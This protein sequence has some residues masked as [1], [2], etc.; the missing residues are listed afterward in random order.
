MCWGVIGEKYKETDVQATF[1]GTWNS[2]LKVDFAYEKVGSAGGLAVGNWWMLFRSVRF[3]QNC[4]RIPES[5]S[6]PSFRF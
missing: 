6:F 3:G 2:V 1:Y 5:L 4:L